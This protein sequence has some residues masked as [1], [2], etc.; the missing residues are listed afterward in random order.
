MTSL[1]NGYSE[2]ETI[3]KT[4]A[5]CYDRREIPRKRREMKAPRW[6]VKLSKGETLIEESGTYSVVKSF[7]WHNRKLS[8]SQGLR[9]RARAR[10]ILLHS[11]Y[12]YEDIQ[13]G[14]IL[15]DRKAEI[16]T[17]KWKNADHI[18]S[19]HISCILSWWRLLQ[20]YAIVDPSVTKLEYQGNIELLSRKY[21]TYFKNL[22]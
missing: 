18:F 12:K 21:C 17:K 19:L 14:V 5:I 10:A 15:R 9:A 1:G 16:K 22:A 13:K 11:L 2:N 4:H 7:E 20:R 3:S 6:R 8:V